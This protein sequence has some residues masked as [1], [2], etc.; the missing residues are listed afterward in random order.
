MAK[1]KNVD[2]TAINVT[3]S[4]MV[5]KSQFDELAS[6]TAKLENMLAEL[7]KKV[8]EKPSAEPM[9]TSVAYVPTQPANRMDAI[10]TLVHLVDCDPQLPDN[11]TIGGQIHYFT[12]FGE[13]KSFRW[14]D[15]SNFISTYRVLFTR[16]IFALGSDCEAFRNEIPNDIKLLKLPEHFYTNMASLNIDEFNN[17]FESLTD[18]QRVQVAV[19]WRRK[20][21]SK[22]KGYNNVEKLKIINKL[23]NGTLKDILEELAV[24]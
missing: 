14:G 8:E 13:K 20:Y 24:D 5:P 22:A 23:T 2:T 11:V 9:P 16:G 12:Y 21:L 17:V 10:C 4:E 6:K 15:L 19:S 1:S 7:M 3:E 18:E